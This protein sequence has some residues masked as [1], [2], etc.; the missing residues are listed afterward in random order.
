MYPAHARSSCFGRA[1]RE[2]LMYAWLPTLAFPLVS[3]ASASLVA[4]H[5][6]SPCLCLPVQRSCGP[7]TAAAAAAVAAPASLR[8]AVA[9]MT[10]TMMMRRTRALPAPRATLLAAAAAVQL[11]VALAAGVA[12]AVAA[13]LRAL[14]LALVAPLRARPTRRTWTRIWRPTSAARPSNAVA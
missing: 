7:R 14:R 4:R 9:M 5:S 6:A 1:L 11:A 12:V 8:L 13:L 3:L 2:L 10:M